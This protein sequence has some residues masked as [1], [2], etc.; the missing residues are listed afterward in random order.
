MDRLR[1]FIEA[2]QHASYA[3]AADGDASLASQYSRDISASSV[4]A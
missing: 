3:E 1:R 4:K 2:S